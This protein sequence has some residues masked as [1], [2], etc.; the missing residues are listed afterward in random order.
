[1]EHFCI[2][3]A[4]PLKP[5]IYAG[6]LKTIIWNICQMSLY[7]GNISERTI[8]LICVFLKSVC[9]LLQVPLPLLLR[10]LYFVLDGNGFNW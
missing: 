7:M 9:A 1:M 6:S 10:S 5:T 8:T 2:F 3:Y 4:W